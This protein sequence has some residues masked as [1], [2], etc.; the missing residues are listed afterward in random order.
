ML[1]A[2]L[3]LELP[4]PICSLVEHFADLPDPRDE[5]AKRHPLINVLVIALCALLCGAEDFVAMH[6][7]GQAKHDWLQE[8]L[9]LAAG[10]P[11]HDT[12]GRVFARLDP[13]AFTRC[14]LA[15]VEALQERVPGQVV[16]LDGK[17]LRRSFDTATGQAAIHMVSAWAT[18]SRLV[19]GQI[20][21]EA[22]SNEI[23]AIPALLRLLDI[24]G[25]IVT[26]DAMGTQKAIAQQVKEQGGEYLLALKGNHARLCADVE[27]FFAH[28]DQHRFE[29]QPYDQYQESDQGHGRFE[30]RCCTVVALSA[31]GTLWQDVQQEWSGLC[32]LVRLK[33]ERRM[34]KQVCL[35]TRFYLSSLPANARRLLRATRAHWGIENGLHWVLDVA[36]DEDGCRVRKEHAPENLSTLRHIA[37]NLLRQETTAKLGVKNRRLKA[38][39]D[40]AYLEKLLTG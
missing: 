21:V 11:S 3:L 9:D 37:L 33:S 4:M 30:T 20:K 10:I 25:C 36:F 31:L 24:S 32:S 34:G 22:K 35:E 28:A 38:G 1:K 23:S 12:F 39:W 2:T 16:A 13:G 7:W 18:K 40:L 19:L 8:R 29:E 6:D 27:A 14:F 17:T 5:R 26:C 15:W